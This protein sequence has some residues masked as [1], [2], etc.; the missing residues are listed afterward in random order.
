[1]EPLKPFLEYSY[2]EFELIKNTNQV[3]NNSGAVY[4][5][6][7]DLNDKVVFWINQFTTNKR[8]FMEQ[9]LSRAS[10]YLPMVHQIFTEEHVPKDLAYLAVIESGFMNSASSCAKAVGMWQF[11][12]ATGRDYGLSGDRWVEERRD[13]VKATRAAAKYIKQLY[14]MSG[15]CY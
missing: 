4:D 9:I 14:K 1:V 12:Q 10:Q 15:D 13:P 2:T 6:P 8:H 5:F 3:I 7:I 11:M